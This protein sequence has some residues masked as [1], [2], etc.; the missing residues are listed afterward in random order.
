MKCLEICGGSQLTSQGIVI[1]G[2]D[3]WVYSKPHGEARRGG[4]VYY[5]SSCAAGRTSRLL[6]ADV[7][8]HGN[9]VAALA[10]D[11]R[12]LMR[13]FVNRPDQS[14]F[15]RLL[16]QQFSALSKTGTFATAIVSTF[17]SPSRRLVL[18]NAGHPRPILYRA[19]KEE[20]SLLGHQGPTRLA[21]QPS[22][23][24][25]GIL[26]ATEYENFDIELEPGDCL[27]VYTDALIES[28][29][30]DGQ[31]L[32]ED[33]VLRL[34]KLLGDITAEKLI[35]AL[36]EEIADR[37]PENLSADDVTVMIL[38]ANGRFQSFTLGD[39]MLGAAR[40]AGAAVRSLFARSTERPY[41]SEP[42]QSGT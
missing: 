34:L 4:D 42:G 25:L 22:N 2:L 41:Q 39:K 17:F 33:G 27:V 24:P 9:D 7:S 32:G 16:N 26:S 18:C 29:D 15:V 12:M 3:T 21:A 14:E 6:L 37:Y 10:A 38:R 1:G 30:A 8:G 20:W 13:R 28:S 36:L 5:G 23:L 35:N 11:L 40:M 31:M 19:S